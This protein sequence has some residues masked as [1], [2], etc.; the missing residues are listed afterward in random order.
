MTVKFID[1]EPPRMIR[2]IDW[3]P[4]AEKL[5]ANSG[6]WAIVSIDREGAALRSIVYNINRHKEGAAARVRDNF[7]AVLRNGQLYMRHIP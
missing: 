1:D 6:K 2:R 4:I 3:E 7:E 5:E